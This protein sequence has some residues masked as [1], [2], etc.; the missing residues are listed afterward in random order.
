MNLQNKHALGAPLLHSRASGRRSEQSP[1]PSPSAGSQQEGEGRCRGL[2]SSAPARSLHVLSSYFLRGCRSSPGRLSPAPLLTASCCLCLAFLLLVVLEIQVSNYSREGEPEEALRGN[3]SSNFMSRCLTS[4]LRGLLGDGMSSLSPPPSSFPLLSLS[5]TP[6][7]W[8]GP[9]LG[10]EEGSRLSASLAGRT[11]GRRHLSLW[12]GVLR[13]CQVWGT[14]PAHRKA[15]PSVPL[16]TPW[17]APPSGLLGTRVNS[18]E[19][20]P[21]QAE[22]EALQPVPGEALVPLS[23]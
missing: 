20:V 14:Y 3:L 18:G 5:P 23:V 16:T 2:S 10:A 4:A 15:T 1:W 19:L 8:A 22:Q 9:E 12:R 21:S 7:L 6:M 17:L 13:C 11:L